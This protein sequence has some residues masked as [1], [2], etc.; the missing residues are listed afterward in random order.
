MD[1]EV[2]KVCEMHADRFDCPD[3]LVHYI[4]KF[5]E[6]GLIIHDGG[7][8]SLLITYCPWCGQG[9]PE[10]KRDQWFEVIEALGLE[11]ASNDIPEEYRSDA[12]YRSKDL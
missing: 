1:A 2:S 7:T 6:Y 10:S 12:W 3:A 8:S 9:L 11:P 5:D 4:P